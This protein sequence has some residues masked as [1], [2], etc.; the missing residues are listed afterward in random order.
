MDPYIRDFLGFWSLK[1]PFCKVLGIGVLDSGMGL[2]VCS[3]PGLNYSK[4]HKVGNL[5]KAK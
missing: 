4:P 3:G 2:W 5:I 1:S